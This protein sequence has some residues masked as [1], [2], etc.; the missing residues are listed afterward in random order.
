MKPGMK[1]MVMDRMRQGEQSRNEYGGNQN[2]RMIGFD[3]DPQRERSNS[4]YNNMPHMPPM[5]AY[6]YGG[7]MSYGGGEMNY[8]RSRGGGQ[9][10]PNMGGY[11]SEMAY[12]G[13]RNENRN[14]YRN[15]NRGG[16]QGYARMGGYNEG[17]EARRRR[18]R[19]GRYAMGGEYEDEEEEDYSPKGRSEN[20]TRSHYGG[21]Y[22]DVFA[23]GMIY[24]PGAMNRPMGSMMGGEM[25]E[26]V[27]E[28]TAR[29]WVQNMSGGEK[30]KL[31]QA[32]QYRSSICPECNRYEY[33]VALNAMYS[34]YCETAKKMGM[35]KPEFYAYL[36]KD[37]L[38]DKDA[39]PHKLR[40]YMMTIPK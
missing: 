3:R 9:D 28:H 12:G 6:G 20:R 27:D 5:N 4:Q 26:P 7:E 38:M 17:P 15:E 13:N 11:E 37:F 40:K 22:G 10:K 21:S 25:S 34:D 1:M 19:R 24:A 35:D 39:G 18:D 23:E 33:Y 31:E 2:R 8:G 32:D 36:A 14:E 16:G 30:F 29:K